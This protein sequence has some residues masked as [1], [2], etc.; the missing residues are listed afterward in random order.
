MNES[1]LEIFLAKMKDAAS[2]GSSA[3]KDMTDDGRNPMMQRWLYFTEEQL[4]EQAERIIRLCVYPDMI[5]DELLIAYADILLVSLG[6]MRRT[7]RLYTFVGDNL[8]GHILAI[9]DRLKNDLNTHEL[10]AQIRYEMDLIKA[11]DE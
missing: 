1:K 4:A 3:P 9:A 5:P 2:N 8:R 7:K 10:E 11:N 6:Q